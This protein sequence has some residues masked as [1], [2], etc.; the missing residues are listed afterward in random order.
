MEDGSFL[1]GE[2]AGAVGVV[3][4]AL[5]F[6]AAKPTAGVVMAYGRPSDGIRAA[7]SAV[8]EA[9]GELTA[10][11]T[12]AEMRDEKTIASRLRGM[13]AVGP[14]GSVVVSL[15]T[16]ELARSSLDSD[17]LFED[18]G[19]H[20]VN[21]DG[22]Q[23]RLFLVVHPLLVQAQEHS[24][25]E[26]VERSDGFVGRSRELDEIRHRMDR[27]RIVTVIG[28]SGIGKSALIRRYVAEHND[29]FLDGVLEI[30]LSSVTQSAV[31]LPMMLRLASAVRLPLQRH[32]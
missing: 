5:V 6:D 3:T 19:R 2:R 11:V 17:Y 16:Q 32:G 24:E 21:P 4:L 7:V 27:A 18:I 23:E 13:V 25:P 22:H 8:A 14:P 29:E 1:R 15:A 28:P 20:V 9:R 26:E 30:D 12:T 31:V 10:A